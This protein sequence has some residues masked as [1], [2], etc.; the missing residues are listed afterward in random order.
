MEGFQNVQK[1]FVCRLFFC[2]SVV[3][4]VNDVGEMDLSKTLREAEPPQHTEWKAKNITDNRDLHNRAARY[5][6]NIGKEI[7]KALD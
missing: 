1:A 4:V 2:F 5:I 3:I 7:Q 6:R